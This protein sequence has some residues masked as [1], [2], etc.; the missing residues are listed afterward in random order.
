M[1]QE[2][3]MLELQDVLTLEN[4]L[5]NAIRMFDTLPIDQKDAFI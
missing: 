2:E 5:N 4:I 1:D 3:D